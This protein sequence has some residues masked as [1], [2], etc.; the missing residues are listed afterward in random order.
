MDHGVLGVIAV[1]VDPGGDLASL[2]AAEVAGRVDRLHGYQEW[3]APEFRIEFGSPLRDVGVDGE[4]LRLPPPW[5]FPVA[6]GCASH[7]DP[8]QRCCVAR[9]GTP[10]E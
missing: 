6:A 4:A 3:T 2:V 8:D 9:G 7:P 5:V 1:T 10:G